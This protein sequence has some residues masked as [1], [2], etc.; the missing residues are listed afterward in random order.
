MCVCGGGGGGGGM[1]LCV[2]VCDSHQYVWNTKSPMEVLHISVHILDDCM[3]VCVRA[4]VR[5]CVCVTERG[6][7]QR[8]ASA[9]T[10]FTM[11]KCHQSVW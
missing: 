8:N 3:C 5:A 4:C 1:L 7:Q 9:K 2:C 11:E 6:E 10:S